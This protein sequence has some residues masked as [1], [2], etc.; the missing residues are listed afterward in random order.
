MFYSFGLPFHLARNIPYYRRAFT[1]AANNY[2]SGYQP[3]GYNK[4]RTSLLADERRHV[5][6]LL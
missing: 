6:N 1:F 4:L 5:E 3:Q 2:I